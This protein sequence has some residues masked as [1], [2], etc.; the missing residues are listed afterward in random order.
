MVDYSVTSEATLRVSPGNM[1]PTPVTQQHDHK[2]PTLGYCG[3]AMRQFGIV[4]YNASPLSPSA[5]AHSQ[6]T[7]GDAGKCDFVAYCVRGKSPYTS[8]D[9][10][11]L[12]LSDHQPLQAAQSLNPGYDP[13]P[14]TRS[15]MTANAVRF[16]DANGQ[17]V[18]ISLV[19]C[20]YVADS[21][22]DSQSN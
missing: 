13:T 2:K 15:P 14:S 10:A 3:D 21:Y 20:D 1:M 11:Y 19:L 16:A 17:A 7:N 18:S 12:A 22:A 9:Y 8:M 5:W 4:R 6:V